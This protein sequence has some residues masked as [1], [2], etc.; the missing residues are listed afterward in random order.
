MGPDFEPPKWDSVTDKLRT[1]WKTVF[2]LA[3]ASSKRA[4]ELHALSRDKADIVFSRDS[5]SLRTVPGFLPKNQRLHFDPK[6]FSV[7]KL[8]PF[9]GRDSPDHL[10]CPVRMLKYYLNFTKGPDNSSRRLF[11]K[12]KGEGNVVSKTISSWLKNC[13]VFCHDDKSLHAKGHEVR[14]MS[15]S[16]AFFSGVDIKII[17]AAG[18]WASTS[19]FTS[20]YLADVQRQIDGR[21]RFVVASTVPPGH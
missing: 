21:F 2:L 14:R 1:V 11:V 3:L 15:S 18:S 10:L 8:S 12:V 13:I 16:W 4:S 17:L 6:P 20:F 5:V 19:T 9:A 7:P